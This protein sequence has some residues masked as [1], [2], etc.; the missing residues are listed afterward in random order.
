MFLISLMKREINVQNSDCER[1]LGDLISTD[2]K[3]IK[4]ILARKSKGQGI[5]KAILSKLEDIWFGTYYFEVAIMFRQSL[6][7]N[8]ILHNSEVWYNLNTK[9]IQELAS[10]DT[11]VSTPTCMLF[12][13]LGCIPLRCLHYVLQQNPYSLLLKCLNVQI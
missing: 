9:E 8:S 4:N 6:F 5:I 12:L 11:E 2:A 10:V 7:L 13:K 3:N 1:Y